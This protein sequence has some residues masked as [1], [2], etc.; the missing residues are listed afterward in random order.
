MQQTFSTATQARRWLNETAA[1]A[2]LG[3][4]TDTHP[5]DKMTIG[6]L[7]ER[8]RDDCMAD[9]KADRIGHIPAIL[10]DASRKVGPLLF[11]GN[12]NA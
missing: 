12:L 2:E 11:L 3:Q 5:F 1:K 9:R 7:V 8:Y 4:F 10:R 6:T